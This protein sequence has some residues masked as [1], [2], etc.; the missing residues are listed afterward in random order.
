M[1]ILFDGASTQY[2]SIDSTPVTAAPF[3]IACWF[4][5]DNDDDAQNLMWIGDKDSANNYFELMAAAHIAGN[6]VVIGITEGAG[7]VYEETT[8]GFAINAWHHACAVFVSSTS[9]YPYLDGGGAVEHTVDKSP[10]GSDR[11]RI[12]Y[13]GDSSPNIP[14]S[15]R[16]AEAGLWN[17]AL[18][19]NEVLQLANGMLPEQVRP[20]SLVSHWPMYSLTMLED[21]VGGYDMT[22]V[23]TP[24]SAAHDMP[25]VTPRALVMPH[26]AAAPPAGNVPEMMRYYRNM[27]VA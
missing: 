27:R 10:A 17:A 15:G 23:N 25:I 18:S 21:V 24:T 1:A 8:T 5:C 20:G 3:T 9:R 16:I 13:R 11:I 26:V 14:F 12:A 2:L 4:Y 19:A 7:Y 6:P 22:A